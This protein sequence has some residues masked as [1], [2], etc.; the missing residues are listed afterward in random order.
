MSRVVTLL[1]SAALCQMAHAGVSICGYQ[2]SMLQAWDARTSPLEG[3]LQN[4]KNG[5]TFHRSDL[6]ESLLTG[7]APASLLST[8]W[9]STDQPFLIPLVGPRYSPNV[10]RN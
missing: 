3:E 1:G 2:T 7:V 8:A 9:R 6:A 5:W 4:P 10:A